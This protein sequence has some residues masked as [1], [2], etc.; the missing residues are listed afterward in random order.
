MGLVLATASAGCSLID[1]LSGGDPDDPGIPGDPGDPVEPGNPGNP[2]NPACVSGAIS[3]Q[4]L[5]DRSAS[6]DAEIDYD[7]SVTVINH[8][9]GADDGRI[10][11]E[12]D[13]GVSLS[14]D[15]RLDGDIMPLEND[16]RYHARIIKRKTGNGVRDDLV[17]AFRNS[18]GGGAEP[19][20]S[21]IF[22]AWDTAEQSLIDQA[23][24]D[25]PVFYQ[26]QDCQP[27][28]DGC[29]DRIGLDLD[30]TLPGSNQS[31][32]VAP[33]TEASI[34]GFRVVN[35]ST[36]GEYVTPCAGSSVQQLSGHI[37]L[38]AQPIPI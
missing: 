13:V 24:L 28:S 2:G 29:G 21:L 36:S 3:T 34:P 12:L 35:N 11:F 30:V 31:L 25:F 27:V 33:G 32:V 22:V 17:L 7:G 6:E 8:Q 19:D 4:L 14:L 10:T 26:P 16:K 20:A 23:V 5:I 37:T 38:P 15:Y 1:G 18:L 9:P